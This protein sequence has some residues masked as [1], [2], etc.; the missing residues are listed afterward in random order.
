MHNVIVSIDTCHICAEWQIDTW[1]KAFKYQ[2]NKILL[3]AINVMHFS[4]IPSVFV[5]CVLFETK[6]WRNVI[7]ILLTKILTYCCSTWKRFSGPLQ[8]LARFSALQWLA[9][10]ASRDG[11]MAVPVMSWH[12]PLRHALLSTRN[13]SEG[14]MDENSRYGWED[15]LMDEAGFKQL[16]L[17][18]IKK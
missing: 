4:T 1:F 7:Q 17:W 14:F 16:N 5:F 13:L 2:H 8:V 9:H 11:H 18:K 6:W 3:Q 12:N 10:S 15:H